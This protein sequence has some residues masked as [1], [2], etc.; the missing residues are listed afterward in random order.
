MI[1]KKKAL[2]S[3]LCICILLFLLPLGGCSDAIE[4]NERVLVKGI[5]IDVRDGIYEIT[6]HLFDAEASGESAPDDINV[7]SSTGRSV[8]EA[9]D[10]LSLKTGKE[11]LFSQNL[12]LV[13]GEDTAVEGVYRIIDSF[14]RYY[15]ARPTVPILIAH[16][17]TARELMNCKSGGEL[18]K[19]NVLADIA[20]AGERNSR[21][22]SVTML[23]FAGDLRSTFAQPYAASARLEADGENCSVVSDGTAVFKEDKLTGFLNPEET[24]GFLL[25]TGNTSGGS[26]SVEVPEIGN[27]TFSILSTKS[28]V[29]TSLSEGLP[30]FSVTVWVEANIYEI[31]HT[32]EEKL[33]N[34]YFSVLEEALQK[35]FLTLTEQTLYILKNNFQSD[36]LNLGRHLLKSQ[37]G[38]FKTVEKRWANIFAESEVQVKINVRVKRIGQEVSPL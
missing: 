28:Q 6:L 9:I 26:E 3:F 15:E 20:T 11:G 10:N 37:P 36:I 32:L 34:Q 29:D 4:L 24:R 5:G 13:I 16:G 33:P 35:R 1:F 31:N 8:F 25:L 30:R 27:V 14:V 12:I 18:I 2:L 19:P 22:Q 23:T 17:C 38:Y 21:G 7:V